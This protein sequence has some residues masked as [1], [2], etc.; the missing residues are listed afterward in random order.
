[1]SEQMNDPDKQTRIAKRIEFAKFK[2]SKRFPYW[3]KSQYKLQDGLCAW[4]LDPISPTMRDVHIDHALAL[5][6]GGTNK[7][8]NLVLSHAKCNM[9]KWI[10]VDETPLWI[11]NKIEKKAN[12]QRLG[13]LRAVQARQAQEL[14]D[15]I[16]YEDNLAWLRDERPRTRG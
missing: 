2:K 6:H 11:Q 10:R 7:T 3:L 1:M 16:T 14:L 4:C 13:N 9:S 5:Y 15:E 8:S 12:S